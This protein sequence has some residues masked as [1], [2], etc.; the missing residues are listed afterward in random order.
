LRLTAQ[1]LYGVKQSLHKDQTMFGSNARHIA[2]MKDLQNQTVVDILN[3]QVEI[4][5]LLEHRLDVLEAR[6]AQEL[7][8]D[9][10]VFLPDPDEEILP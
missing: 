10:A 3:R 5:L 1:L 4:N 8:P 9:P 2:T 6:A 7:A